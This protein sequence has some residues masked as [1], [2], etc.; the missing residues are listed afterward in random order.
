[1]LVK[2]INYIN[3]FVQTG[4][5]RIAIALNIGGSKDFRFFENR[6]VRFIGDRIAITSWRLIEQRSAR[7]PAQQEWSVMPHSKKRKE[8][9]TRPEVKKS[10]HPFLKCGNAQKMGKELQKL[11]GFRGSGCVPPIFLRLRARTYTHTHVHTLF[12]VNP[13]HF[14]IKGGRGIDARREKSRAANKRESIF[15]LE[16]VSEGR[17]TNSSFLPFVLIWFWSSRHS[18]RRSQITDEN[19][20]CQG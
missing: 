3:C 12:A 15:H 14:S 1:M 20:K 17:A 16:I 5:L 7:L 19:R 11:D 9:S 13:S 10:T 4:F 8:K 2:N 6:S 18:T